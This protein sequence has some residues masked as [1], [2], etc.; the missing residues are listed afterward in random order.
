MIP[1]WWE[2]KIPYGVQHGKK[3]KERERERNKGKKKDYRRR[4]DYWR[5]ATDNVGEDQVKD[6]D[7]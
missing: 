7:K 2:T 3:K 1:G 6:T 5:K 4:W